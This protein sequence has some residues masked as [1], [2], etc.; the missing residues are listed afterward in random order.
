MKAP[1]FLYYEL[2]N[3]YTNHRD[4]VRS[5]S[6]PQLRGEVHYDTRTS[7]RCQG[8][9]L[10][11]EIFD[12]DSSKY[13]SWKGKPLKGDDFAN[14][15]GLIAKSFFTDTYKLLNSNG[16]V[17]KINETGISNEYDRTYMFKRY[18]E[19]ETKQWINVEDGIL[20]LM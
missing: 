11:K 5:K 13:I 7:D 17:I 9:S 10:V 18:N 12:N 2:N 15:C 6:Y 20:A 8:A 16:N 4:F 3:F 19:S 14:P 1:I